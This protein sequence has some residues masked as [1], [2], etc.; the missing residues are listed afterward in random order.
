MKKVILAYSGGLDTS[1]LIRWYKDK[2]YDVIAY[3][4]D[5]GQGSDFKLIEKR[6][7]ATGASKVYILDLKEEFVKDYVFPAIKANAVYEGK[8]FLATALSRPLIAKHQVLVA[9]KEK[10]TVLSHG[11]TGKGND[12]VRLEVTAK[13]LAP[14]LELQAP[15]RTWELKTRDQE[16]E[17]A[18]KHKIPI[19]VTKK[20][21]YSTDI[22]LYGR[23]IE[24]GILEDPWVE[25]P[26]EIYKMTKNP[27]KCPNKPEYVEIEYARGIPVKVNGKAYKPVDLIIK[28]NE[29]GGRNGVGRVDMVENRLVGIKSRE[30]Y[31]NPAGTLLITSHKELEAMVLD[32]ETLHYKE[33]ISPKYA[34]LTYYGLWETPQKQQLDAYINKTQER[35]SGVVRLKLL[36]GSCNVVGRKS[37][38]SRYK[39]ELATYGAKDIFDPKLSEGFIRIWG[40]PY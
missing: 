5:V 22:N 32:R 13:I 39:E 11:C 28:L 3:L 16:I 6:A 40:M 18:H 34:E 10:A 19:D 38:F 35:V 25:P 36:K 31:E 27:L 17:Y 30:I 20:S 1:C 12:Q 24:C 29:I 7:L 9:K 33:L 37:P 15:L 21:P 2:G 26:E 23:S 4:A 8:Y 14:H